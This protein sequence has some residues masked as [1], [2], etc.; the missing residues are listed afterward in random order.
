MYVDGC[1][2]LCSFFAY[3]HGVAYVCY[4]ITTLVSML[5]WPCFC[6]GVRCCVVYVML[7]DVLPRLVLTLP[8]MC[9]LIY[10][11]LG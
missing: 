11:A 9:M 5:R 8:S 10:V 7:C 3:V 6:C 1:V 4:G 2:W